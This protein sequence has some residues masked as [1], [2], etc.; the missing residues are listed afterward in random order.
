MF[1]GV[2]NPAIYPAPKTSSNM[3]NIS[4]AFVAVQHLLLSKRLEDLEKLYPVP[5]ALDP[6]NELLSCM[7]TSG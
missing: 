5:L 6:S 1:I 2:K 3:A 4:A 7:V